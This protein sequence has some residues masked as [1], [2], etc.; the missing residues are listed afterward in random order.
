MKYILHDWD[1]EMTLTFLSMIAGS[2][3][4]VLFEKLIFGIGT[5]IVTFAI[6]SSFYQALANVYGLR[7][8]SY[9][10]EYNIR[11]PTKIKLPRL[12][13]AQRV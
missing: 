2:V 10:D 5:G 8:L 6:L 1:R 7:N 3:V 12:R 9:I 13:R 4:W 11:L